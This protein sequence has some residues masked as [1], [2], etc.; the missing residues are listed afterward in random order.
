[1]VYEYTICVSAVL[2]VAEAKRRNGAGNI[3][4]LHITDKVYHIRKN[5]VIEMVQTNRLLAA[6]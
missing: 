3:V 2:N 6:G 5:H 4:R 1:M